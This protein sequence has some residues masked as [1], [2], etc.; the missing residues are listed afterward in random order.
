[1]WMTIQASKPEVSWSKYFIVVISLSFLM[2]E[3]GNG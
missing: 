3:N 1:M 2:L